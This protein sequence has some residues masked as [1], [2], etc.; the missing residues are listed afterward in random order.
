MST[1]KSSDHVPRFD[2]RLDGEIGIR[3]S[4]AATSVTE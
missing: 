3:Q 1:K 2:T 4:Q